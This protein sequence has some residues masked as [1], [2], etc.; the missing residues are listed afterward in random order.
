MTTPKKHHNLRCCLGIPVKFSDLDVKILR[1]ADI[2]TADWTKNR[3]NT[4]GV[5][6]TNPDGGPMLLPVKQEN[7]PIQLEHD[8][9]GIWTWKEGANSEEYDIIPYLSLPKPPHCKYNYYELIFL[10]NSESSPESQDSLRFAIGSDDELV[11]ILETGIAVPSTFSENLLV[12]YDYDEEFYFCV[13]ITKATSCL[14]NDQLLFVTDKKSLVR[15]KIERKDVIDSFD[16]QY[17]NLLPENNAHLTRRLIYKKMRIATQDKLDTLDLHSDSVLFARYFYRIATRLNYSNDEKKLLNSVVIEALSNPK[18][19]QVV[20]LS[21]ENKQWVESRTEIIRSYLNTDAEVE[22]FVRGV[23]EHVP[24]INEEYIDKI[25]HVAIQGLFEK[26]ENLESEILDLKSKRDDITGDILAITGKQTAAMEALRSL[27]KT[28]ESES[29]RIKADQESRIKQELKTFESDRKKIAIEEIAAFK[30]E[31]LQAI[32]KEG[33]L[34]RAEQKNAIQNDLQS[35]CE[36]VNRLQNDIATLEASRDQLD[37]DISDR[38]RIQEELSQLE[39]DKQTLEETNEQL[40]TY[41]EQK[42][43]DIQHN[44]GNTLGDLALFKGLMLDGGSEKPSF[45]AVPNSN[46]LIRPAEDY[47]LDPIEIADIENLVYDLKE[48]LQ[49]IGVDQEYA[50]SLAE[51]VAGAY[52]TRTPLLLTGC[53]ASLMANAIS[54]TLCSQTPEI[55]SVPTGYNDYFSLLNTVRNTSGDV[56]LLQNVIGSIDEGCYMHLAKDIADEK[57]GKYI[58]YSLDFAETMRILPPSVLGYMVLI[59]SEDVITSVET[60]DL[61]AGDCTIVA[62]VE[63]KANTKG[64]YQNIVQL[65]RGMGTTNGYNL[66]R[67][68]ILSTIA[69]KDEKNVDDIILL[70]L[71][72]YCKLL[73]TTNELNQRLGYL[74]RD[75]LK[76]I[77]EKLLG[78]E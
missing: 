55:I 25:Q 20:T 75:D 48:N 76:K 29:K 65:S 13:E 46:L 7:N 37:N 19:Q 54:V 2:S 44:L 35:L 49:N 71:A 23:I 31:Q 15:Y 33:E 32:A 30:K 11:R 34:F 50:E 40:K 63:R 64:L 47:G 3:V 59:N 72:T 27:N 45:A 4:I 62:P 42:L 38:Q 78:G 1:I 67:S 61:N 9:I 8:T 36:E 16:P 24:N 68:T 14:R 22:E 28:V 53:T 52:L 57:P 10:Q 73:G 18:A 60:E 56:V 69:A 70:E 41:C 12:V 58:L 66:T 21:S 26:K 5:I 51:L 77:V 6:Y 74:G 17:K 39:Q 43:K